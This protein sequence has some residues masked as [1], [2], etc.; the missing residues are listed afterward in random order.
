MFEVV[1]LPYKHF[2]RVDRLV[3]EDHVG[4]LH[5]FLDEIDRPEESYVLDG[6]Q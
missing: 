3:H 5:L 4:L 2:D 1:R 6:E